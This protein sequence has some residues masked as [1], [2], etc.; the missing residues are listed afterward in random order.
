MLAKTGPDRDRTGKET[1]RAGEKQNMKGR[2]TG[3][4]HGRVGR[5]KTRPYRKETG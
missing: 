5:R 2:G 4:E 1:W 3:K